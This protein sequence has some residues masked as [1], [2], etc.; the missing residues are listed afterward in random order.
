MGQRPA[1]TVT[2]AEQLTPLPALDSG[3]NAA[4]LLDRQDPGEAGLRGLLRKFTWQR[5]NFDVLRALDYPAFPTKPAVSD[6]VMMECSLTGYLAKTDEESLTPLETTDPAQED[7]ISLMRRVRHQEDLARLILRVRERAA[8]ARLAA[9]AREQAALDALTPREREVLL[10]VC[11]GLSSLEIS[12]RLWVGERTV[13]T[14][15]T[16]LLRKLHVTT[17]IHLVRFAIRHGLI[18]P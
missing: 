6:S 3:E 8:D 10:L 16:R 9:L 5:I 18:E 4:I 13:E 11:E 1:P 12:R 14:H 7:L 15:R 17:T 2:G